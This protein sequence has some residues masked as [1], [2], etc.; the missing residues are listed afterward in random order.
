MEENEP[1]AENSQ[2]GF[3]FGLECPGRA[4][5]ENGIWVNKCMKEDREQTSGVWEKR[6]AGRGSSQS[7]G[8]SGEWLVCQRQDGWSAGSEEG[9][10]GRE[11]RDAGLAKAPGLASA[12]GEVGCHRGFSA[13]G[14][15]DT[16]YI[17]QAHSCLLFA[18]WSSGIQGKSRRSIREDVVV[19]GGSWQ[20]QAVGT[21]ETMKWGN[22]QEPT[23]KMK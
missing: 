6:L 4:Y 22:Q 9:S 3:S 16:V 18:G 19:P 8:P 11:P 14:Q 17:L 13:G 21:A 15:H 23:L 2:S 12:A 1:G 20:A 5:W 7:K 10:S